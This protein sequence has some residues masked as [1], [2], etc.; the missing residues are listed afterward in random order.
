ALGADTLGAARTRIGDTVAVAGPD[1][2]L[3]MRVVGQAV[4]PT[5]ADAYPLADGAVLSKRAVGVLGEG[6]SFH[7]LAIR[8]RP[9]ADRAAAFARLD[10]LDARSDPGNSPPDRPAPPSEIE[11]LRQVESLPKVLAVFLALLGVVALAHALVVGV[12]R[13]ARDFAVLRTLGFRARESRAAVA[14]AAGWLAVV[15]A[16]LGIA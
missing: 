3:A 11:K 16:V 4:F 13:R 9:G 5:G 10:A 12:R 1:G 8:Y 14:W 2:K 7:N 6:D 15:G